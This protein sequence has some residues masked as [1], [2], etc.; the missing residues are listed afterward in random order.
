VIKT[1]PV[2]LSRRTALAVALAVCFGPS[3]AFASSG[4]K[5][6]MVDDPNCRY[7]RQFDAEIGGRYAK[8]DEGR[9]APLVR[10]R[11]KSPELKGLNPV[12]Y[13]P[14]FLLVRNGEELGRITGYPGPEYFFSEL[15]ELL[16]R[17]SFTGRVKSLGRDT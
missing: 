5:L 7:C 12:I 14:T 6:I 4:V 3:R 13:T 9:F 1:H 8:T 11:R 10:V 15:R 16:G 17:T 2:V